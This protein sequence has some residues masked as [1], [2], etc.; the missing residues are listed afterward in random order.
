MFSPECP[1]VLEAWFRWLTHMQ[2]PGFLGRRPWATHF[3]CRVSGCRR[4]LQGRREMPPGAE[5]PGTTCWEALTP[6]VSVISRMVIIYIIDNLSDQ[7][8]NIYWALIVYQALCLYLEKTDIMKLQVCSTIT[9]WMVTG[10]NA[11]GLCFKDSESKHFELSQWLLPPGWQPRQ[12]NF[13]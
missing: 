10:R 1:G 3:K 9:S 5:L 8:I 12:F 13:F 2:S 4:V 11:Q 6:V 7:W